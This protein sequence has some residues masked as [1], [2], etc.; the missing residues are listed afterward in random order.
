MST[1]ASLLRGIA[2]CAL[3]ACTGAATAQDK[4]FSF[5]Y[6]QPKTSAYGFGYLSEKEAC[7]RQLHDMVRAARCGERFITT[8]EFN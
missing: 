3:L 2:L 5:A 6:D 7:L 8:D 1:H 4:Q